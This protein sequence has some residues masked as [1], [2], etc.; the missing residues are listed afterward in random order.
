VDDLLTT[1]QLEELLQ[2]DRTTIYRMLKDGR[3]TG[4]KVGNQWRFK[5]WDVEMLLSS[6][7]CPESGSEHGPQSTS[8]TPSTKII[9]PGCLQVIQ[10]VFAESAGVGAVIIT[11]NGELLTKLS[12]CCRFCN[13]IMASGLGR[14]SCVNLWRELA[15]QPEDHPRFVTCHA[16]LQYIG[17][18]IKV[19]GHFEGMLVAG[20]FYAQPPEV[21]EEQARIDQL[22]KE[23]DLDAQT[24]AEAAKELPIF[25]DHKR[26]QLGVWL[27]NVVR[28]LT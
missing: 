17:A 1:K 3:L 25:D 8:Y 10:D 19:N 15:N 27:E 2:I 24:L 6:T 4:V 7:P 9:P 14:R 23:L 16:G 20:Q 26:A 12:N 5:R 21:G 22:A 13:L 28:H 18:H 11:S